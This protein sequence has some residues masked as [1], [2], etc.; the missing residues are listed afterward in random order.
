MCVGGRAKVY[1]TVTFVRLTDSSYTHTHTHSLTH[2]HTLTHR[3]LVSATCAHTHML[4]HA[5]SLEYISNTLHAEIH[6]LCMIA[7]HIIYY[8]A[9]YYFKLGLIINKK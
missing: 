1:T 2:T 5:L 7:Q 4:T 3:E 9:L 8:T 6:T